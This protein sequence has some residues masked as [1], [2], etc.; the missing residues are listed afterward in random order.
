MR[1]TRLERHRQRCLVG[2]T[3]IASIRL[4]HD[5]RLL[6]M[7]AHDVLYPMVERMQQAGAS[8][9]APRPPSSAS[10]ACAAALAQSIQRNGTGG[11]S[12]GSGAQSPRVNRDGTWRF[13]SYLHPV[14]VVVVSF[15]QSRRSTAILKPFA[16]L[17]RFGLN[18][19]STRPR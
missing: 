19:A 1:R 9:H 10:Q 7:D 16:P 8:W 5:T 14:A 4:T 18:I 17:E 2:A 13:N 12:G 15:S 3:R 6:H 11:S